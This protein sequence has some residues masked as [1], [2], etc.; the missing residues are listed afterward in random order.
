MV[1]IKVSTD[2]TSECCI[3]CLNS[4]LEKK[5]G[6]GQSKA[7]REKQAELEIL[8]CLVTKETNEKL[9][10]IQ[11]KKRELMKKEECVKKEEAILKAKRD[12]GVFK[13][14]S[15]RNQRK[16]LQEAVKELKKAETERRAIED[17]KRKQAEEEEEIRRRVF[18]EE[19]ARADYHR[20]HEAHHEA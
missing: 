13:K 6:W 5:M 17:K 18:V 3:L 9:R 7:A 15:K 11:E 2:D 4:H 10:V 12:D 14:S 19:R 1:S 8:Q 20:D 16:N